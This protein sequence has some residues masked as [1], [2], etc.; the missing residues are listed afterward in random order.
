MASPRGTHTLGNR[1]IVKRTV[2][3]GPVM[4]ILA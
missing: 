4:A 2:L 1:E 3:A